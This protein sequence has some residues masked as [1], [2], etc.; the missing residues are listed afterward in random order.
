MHANVNA[1]IIPQKTRISVTTVTAADA[2]YEKV[3]TSTTF[4]VIFTNI[5]RKYIRIKLN[6]FPFNNNTHCIRLVKKKNGSENESI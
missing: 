1:G 4:N 5:V 6:I 3:G 2:L